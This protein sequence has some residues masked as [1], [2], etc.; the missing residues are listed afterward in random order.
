MDELAP[1]FGIVVANRRQVMRWTV[2]RPFPI[3]YG[4]Y[5]EKLAEELALDVSLILYP[6][7]AP[8]L[9]AVGVLVEVDEETGSLWSSGVLSFSWLPREQ[10]LLLTYQYAGS[11]QAPYFTRPMLPRQVASLL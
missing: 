3:S 10:S 9:L 1:T 7:A 8:G 4:G 5:F 6:G 2:S 11:D